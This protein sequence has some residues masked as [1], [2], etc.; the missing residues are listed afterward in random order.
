[1]EEILSLADIENLKCVSANYYYDGHVREY[2]FSCKMKDANATI[3]YE[4]TDHDNGEW[5]FTIHSEP[6]DVWKIMSLSDLRTLEE[7]LSAEAAV[8]P[9]VKG[10]EEAENF[11]ELHEVSLSLADDE[12]IPRR[13]YDRFRTAYEEKEAFLMAKEEREC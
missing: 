7:T 8:Y 10:V 6:L 1:M 11:E 2:K 13:A 9:Y 4:L 3:T 12:N 5:G